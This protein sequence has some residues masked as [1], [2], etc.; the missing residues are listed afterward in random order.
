ME[1]E[2]VIFRHEY[3]PYKKQW[4]YLAL[5]P[6]DEARPGYIE[7]VGFYKGLMNIWYFEPFSEIS[8]DYMYSKQIIH[9]DHPIIPVLV[10]VI[11]ERYQIKVKVIE[12]IT[13]R[14]KK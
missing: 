5:F 14:K 2:R 3:D 11:E 4:G 13:R 10:D 1:T 9:K 6:D 7:G 8:L 12:R